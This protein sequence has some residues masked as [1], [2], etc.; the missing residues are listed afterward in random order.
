MTPCQPYGSACQPAAESS[1]QH[2]HRS[3]QR[4]RATGQSS[5]HLRESSPRLP[6]G[7]RV[8]SASVPAP[9]AVL[10][11]DTRQAIP[12]YRLRFNDHPLLPVALKCRDVFSI[13]PFSRL[14]P[15]RKQQQ[16]GRQQDRPAGE[17][18]AGRMASAGTGPPCGCGAIEVRG[19][20]NGLAAPGRQRWTQSE[21]VSTV[22][23][24]RFSNL[25][26]E[27]RNCR[28]TAPVGPFRC[29]VMITSATPRLSSLCS[30]QSGSLW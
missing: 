19:H 11:H 23:G 27:P 30:I 29:L 26:I 8:V 22:E 14:Q 5:R 18:A 2:L 3:R 17:R 13:R 16:Q 1:L 28:F 25:R 24:S 7:R 9:T 20:G 4:G 15:P 12:D 6:P 21:M 10:L